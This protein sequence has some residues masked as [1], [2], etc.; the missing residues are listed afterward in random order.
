M[1]KPGD[2]TGCRAGPKAELRGHAR[3]AGGM[4]VWRRVDRR[5]QPRPVRGVVPAEHEGL[6]D[7]S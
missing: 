7:P 5:I 6:R 2:D 1:T 4:V 3:A